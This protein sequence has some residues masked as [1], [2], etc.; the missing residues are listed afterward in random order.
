MCFII[1]FSLLEYL[2]LTIVVFKRNQRLINEFSRMYVFLSFLD[3]QSLKT[4]PMY[5]LIISKAINEN[6]SKIYEFALILKYLNS[7][8][9]HIRKVTSNN[10]HNSIL[11][12]LNGLRCN[13]AII[14][15]ASIHY[16]FCSAFYSA[17][18][19]FT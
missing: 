3:R 2:S 15:F 12:T 9:C 19:N 6:T 10:W 17:F 1:R 5:P 14:I 11:S 7:S 18:P 16:C 13:L 8:V 4:A